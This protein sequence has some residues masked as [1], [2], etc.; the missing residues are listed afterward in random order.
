MIQM[1]KPVEYQEFDYAEISGSGPRI[2][3]EV[4]RI[5]ETNDVE[6]LGRRIREGSI[7]FVNIKPLKLGNAIDFN[8]AMNNLKRRCESSGSGLY[9]ADEGWVLVVPKGIEI[10]R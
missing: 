1:K 5:K 7:I 9:F 2:G 3:I 10:Q 6:R 4:D 8:T